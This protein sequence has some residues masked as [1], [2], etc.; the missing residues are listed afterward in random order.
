VYNLVK[1][2]IITNSKF[3]V[4]KIHLN[5]TINHVQNHQK[6]VQL[7]YHVQKRIKFFVLIILALQ[8]SYNVFSQLNVQ[9]MKFYALINHVDQILINV[10]NQ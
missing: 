7:D 10:Q 1:D 2:V 5:V 9:K 8:V 3:V 4:N 6:N